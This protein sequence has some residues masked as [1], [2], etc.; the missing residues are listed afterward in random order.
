[1]TPRGTALCIL[2]LLVTGLVAPG[3]QVTVS[4]NGTVV[5]PCQY[6]AE[7]TTM[8]WGRGG[9]PNSKCNNEIIWTDGRKVTWQKS[10]RY[11]LLGNISQGDVSLTITGATKEDEG[12]YCCRV[13]IIGPFNDQKTEVELKIQDAPKTPE[14]TPK[15]FHTTRGHKSSYVTPKITTS[16]D[17]VP[18]I[19]KRV[20]QDIL[21]EGTPMANNPLPHIIASVVIIIIILISLTALL[22]TYR[23]CKRRNKESSRNPATISLE[24]LERTEN[25]TEQN[26]YMIN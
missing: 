8:C 15:S 3:A 5:L 13:E 17:P 7:K 19:V 18:S 21:I 4:L 20:S 12:T 24:G 1:M 10:N 11:Q 14:P 9:C 2:V 26:I 23:Y 22:F 25:Q 16:A 6:T